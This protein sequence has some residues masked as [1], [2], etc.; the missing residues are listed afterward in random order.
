MKFYIKDK[1]KIDFYFLG[2]TTSTTF[3]QKFAYDFLCDY[4]VDFPGL[5]N[6][7][8]VVNEKDEE[9]KLC[10]FFNSIRN[11]KKVKDY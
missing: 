9:M 8:A 2:I 3:N 1:P 5:I 6:E 11:L 4:L 7:I 10:D